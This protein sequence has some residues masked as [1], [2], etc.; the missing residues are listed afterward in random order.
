[1]LSLVDVDLGYNQQIILP[2]V[3]L[4]FK[5]NE[6]V[7]ILGPSGVGKTTLLHHLYQQLAEQTC[8]CSQAQGLVDNLSIYHNVF[9]GGLA[10]YSRWYNLA[11]LL[12]PFNKPQQQIGAICQQLELTVPLQQKVNELSGGQRQRVALA[13]ALFQQQ[14]VFMGDEPFSALDPLMGLR[15]LNLIKQTHQSVICVLHDAELALANFERIIVISDGK[16]VLDDKAGQLSLAHLSQHY[17]LA[18]LPN[19]SVA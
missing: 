4:S 1:M 14:A 7:A 19:H 17:A 6:H 16:V 9:I 11:N 8:L 18:D 13:R 5:A 12:L 2:K 10:R 3:N 15:L